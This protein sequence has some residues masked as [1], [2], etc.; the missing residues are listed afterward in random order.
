M[1]ESYSGGFLAQ[2]YMEDCLVHIPLVKNVVVLFFS[3]ITTLQ[4]RLQVATF[5]GFKSFTKHMYLMPPLL[6]K[7]F[8]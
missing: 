6:L 5:L 4:Q 8:H 3:R 1:G 7:I 2:G